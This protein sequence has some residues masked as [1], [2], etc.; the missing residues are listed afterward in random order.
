M[1]IRTT[2]TKTKKKTNLRLSVKPNKKKGI[3]K[4][5]LD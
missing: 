1:K 5:I 2:L 3:G 4:R